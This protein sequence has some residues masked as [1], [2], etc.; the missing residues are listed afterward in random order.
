MKQPYLACDRFL[1]LHKLG[2]GGF[3]L[4]YSGIDL[5][6]NKEVAIKLVCDYYF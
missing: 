2:K 4:I 6:T 3:G 1:L 5:Q